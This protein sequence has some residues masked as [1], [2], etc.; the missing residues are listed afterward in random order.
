MQLGTLKLENPLVLA[1]LAGITDSPFRLLMRQMG[2]AL[3]YSGLASAEALLRWK[4]KEQHTLRL[5]QEERPLAL[6]IF[7][8]IPASIARGTEMLTNLGADV[9]DLNLG[10]T[11][12]KITQGGG[13]IALSLDLSRLEE[14]LQ[15]MRSSTNLPLTLK[16]RL[17]NRENPEQYLKITELALKHNFQGITLHCRTIE[18][19][20]SGHA[21]WEKLRN[22]IPY[23]NNITIIGN[24]DVHTPEDAKYL[25]EEIGCH[26]VM[27]G[28]TCLKNPWIFQNIAAYL[29][30]SKPA[31][32]PLM[33]ERYEVI[34]KLI[35][36]SRTNFGEQLGLKYVK[37]FVAWNTKS[38]PNGARL[39][40]KIQSMKNFDDLLGALDSYFSAL[41]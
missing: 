3:V 4:V 7:G 26:G 31:P 6:Q 25:L 1:P 13:G 5:V 33:P 36:L 24:G 16:M 38:L 22:L 29:K 14:V 34:L 37:P 40:E 41:F 21:D 9:I 2:C 23:K 20:F 32:A 12:P 15:A 19:K 18:Q 27:I 10:C 17:G 30:S 11:M 8:G 35:N 39:R 28:R